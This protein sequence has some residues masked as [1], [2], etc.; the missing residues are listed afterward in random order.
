MASSTDALERGREAFAG[1]FWSD[2]FEALS[3]AD[4]ATPLSADDLELLARAA[5]MLG[6]DD[7]YLGGL[8]RAHHAHLAA[9]EIARAAGCTFWIGHNL[10]FRGE[11]G[12]ATGW[13]ARGQRLLDGGQLDCVERGYLR[14]PALL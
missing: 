7:D 8:E 14:I 13:F 12:P 1:R 3:I 9:G 11:S 10:M 6:R 5:Y 2:A 4:G